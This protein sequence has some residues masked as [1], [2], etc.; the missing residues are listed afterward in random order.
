MPCGVNSGTITLVLVLLLLTAAGEA[1]GGDWGWDDR[2]GSRA[3]WSKL[4]AGPYP[5]MGEMGAEVFWWTMVAEEVIMVDRG[6]SIQARED[7]SLSM[8]VEQV[9]TVVVFRPFKVSLLPFFSFFFLFLL[10]SFP[11]NQPAT[12]STSSLACRPR[13]PPSRNPTSRY[14]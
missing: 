1:C 6:T 2:L 8:M 3:G 13:P 5:L 14:T 11:L 7:L 12:S 4:A 10:S 9:L